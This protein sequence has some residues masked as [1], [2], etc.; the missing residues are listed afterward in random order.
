MLNVSLLLTG[1]LVLVNNKDSGL[2]VQRTTSAKFA[3]TTQ[4]SFI[5]SVRTVLVFVGVSIEQVPDTRD[6][7]I[8]LVPANHLASILTL[9]PFC[10]VR[11]HVLL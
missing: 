1:L 4:L 8:N 5:P 10:P 11:V 3:L 2:T 6:Q 9:D 7:F